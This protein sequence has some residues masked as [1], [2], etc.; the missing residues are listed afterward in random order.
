MQNFHIN[1]L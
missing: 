1:A